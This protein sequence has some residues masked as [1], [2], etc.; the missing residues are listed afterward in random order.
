MRSYKAISWNQATS[1]A[2]H[3][4]NCVPM[5][6]MLLHIELLLMV[7]WSSHRRDGSEG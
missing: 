5:W 6:S 7:C 3:R 2:P 4:A 1:V